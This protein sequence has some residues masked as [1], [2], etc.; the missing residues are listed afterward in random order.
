MSKLFNLIRPLVFSMDAET[1]HGAAIRALSTGLMPHACPIDDDRL[2]TSVFGLDFPNPIGLAPGFDKNAQVPNAM[3]AQGF[4][5]VE[6][7]TV[8][9]RPQQGNPKPRLFRLA[10]DNAVIN[11]MGFNNDGHAAVL[12]RLEQS[13]KRGIIGVNI[14]ANKDS[15]DRIDDYVKGIETFHDIADYLTV[16]IS[17]PNTPGLRGLQSKDELSELLERLNETRQ[18]LDSKTPMLLKIAP[19]LIDEELDDITSVCMR[20]DEQGRMVDG[21]IISNTTLSRDGL[22]SK[23]RGEA[24]GL[25]GEPLFESSTRMLAKAYK[26]TA[27][28]LPLIGVGGI[29]NAEQAFEKICA[30][31]SLVQLYSAMVYHGPDLAHTI[32]QDLVKQLAQHNF[33]SIEQAIGSNVDKWL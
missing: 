17:S 32:A 27:G 9:P 29:S 2:K 8:T 19:D 3:L 15:T 7:G 12:K 24:G 21:L 26:R 33:N 11:R 5:Y 22:T 28:A 1:A 20:S 18:K 13:K 16:N 31:A 10:Q 4:G 25:S 23:W 14:G 30:G 6:I